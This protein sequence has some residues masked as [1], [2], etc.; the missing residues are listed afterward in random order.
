MAERV[1]PAPQLTQQKTKLRDSELDQDEDL[2]ATGV[3]F[4]SKDYWK[5]RWA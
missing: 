5:V 4:D 2:G 3:K 1:Q